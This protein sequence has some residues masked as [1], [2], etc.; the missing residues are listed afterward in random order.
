MSGKIAG[1][2]ATLCTAVIVLTAPISFGRSDTAVIPGASGWELYT[3][4]EYACLVGRCSSDGEI[5]LVFASGSSGEGMDLGSP[6]WELT[7]G[8]AYRAAAVFDK[9]ESYGIEFSA[10]NPN[11]AGLKLNGDLKQAF[12][13]H[14]RVEFRNSQGRHIA[15]IDLTDADIAIAHVN[16]CYQVISGAAVGDMYGGAVPV[17]R[18]PVFMFENT[19]HMRNPFKECKEEEKNILGNID[20]RYRRGNN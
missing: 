9:G 8:K 2:I 12:S 3:D 19:L 16:H 17:K 6:Y 13:T 4:E 20:C 1:R 5:C 18:G 10:E 15:E 7:A 11:R 14:R